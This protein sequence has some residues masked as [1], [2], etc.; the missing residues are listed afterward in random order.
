[1]HVANN[2][3]VECSSEG[4]EA[5]FPF[6]GEMHSMLWYDAIVLASKKQENSFFETFDKVL[7]YLECNNEKRDIYAYGV[8]HDTD[9]CMLTLLK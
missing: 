3:V 1:M 5:V 2:M 9:G 8:T 6:D 4:V 7:E